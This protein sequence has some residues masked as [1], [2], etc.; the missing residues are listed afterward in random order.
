MS[1]LDLAR[2]AKASP[3]TASPA[4]RPPTALAAGAVFECVNEMER[5]ICGSHA[6]PSPARA[7]GLA[8]AGHRSANFLRPPESSAEVRTAGPVSGSPW[9]FHRFAGL[10]LPAN[11]QASFELAASTGQEAVDH[12]L[13]A[14]RLTERTG[15]TGVCT[16]DPPIAGQLDVVQLPRT[17]SLRRFL[18]ASMVSAGYTPSHP[19]ASMDELL[20]LARRTMEEVA[21]FTGRPCPPLH[22]YRMTDARYVV[23]VWG[24]AA[25]VARRAADALR[26]E[27]VRVGVVVPGLIRPFPRHEL[28]A[29]LENRKAVVVVEG[30]PRNHIEFSLLNQVRSALSL[31]QQHAQI[32]TVPD[33]DSEKNVTSLIEHLV[34]LLPEDEAPQKVFTPM[35]GTGLPS[36]RFGVVPNCPWGRRFLLDFAARVHTASPIQLGRPDCEVP[37][38]ASLVLGP[39]MGDD[40]LAGRGQI[41]VLVATHPMLL[42][43]RRMMLMM[44]DHGLLILHS[45]A[46]TEAE[47]WRSLPAD[48]RTAV[49]E[50]GV[51]LWH[52][53][54]R[55][56]PSSSLDWDQTLADLLHGAM[57]RLSAELFDEAGIA[58]PEAERAVREAGPARDLEHA[59]AC[60][61]R[62]AEEIR[63]VQPVDH[64]SRAPEAPLVHM[65]ASP[66][67]RFPDP[68]DIAD[69]DLSVQ[70]RAFH[71]TGESGILAP[72]PAPGFPL[73]PAVFTQWAVPSGR[74]WHFPYLLPDVEHDR[75]DSVLG[76]APLIQWLQVG[77]DSVDEDPTTVALVRRE[78]WRIARSVALRLEEGGDGPGLR[79][80][81]REACEQVV[82]EFRTRSSGRESLRRILNR[83]SETLPDQA[84]LVTAETAAL[85]EFY[86]HTVRR[87]RRP[88]LR[89]FL[90]ELHELL[91]QVED[92]LRIDHLHS[93]RAHSTE[94]L[95]VSLGGAA[96]HMMD[97]GV[98]AKRLPSHRGTRRL[99]PE[100][101]GR[102]TTLAED[103][104][105]FVRSAASEPDFVLVHAG[106]LPDGLDLSGEVAIWQ[107]DSFAVAIG[108]FDGFLEN[109]LSVFRAI[110]Q[111]RLEV[112]H[113]YDPAVHEAP[114][115]RLSVDTLTADELALLPRVV[116]LETE[117]V[118]QRTSLRDFSHVLQSGRPIHTLVL[119]YLT[120]ADAWHRKPGIDG[121][122]PGLSYLSVAHR[123]AFVLQAAL[124]APDQLLDGLAGMVRTPQPAVGFIGVPR[125]SEGAEFHWLQALAAAHGRALPSFT[126]DPDRGDN[127]ATRFDLRSNIQPDE[128]W[129][130]HTVAYLDSHGAH[131]RVQERLTFAHAAALDPAFRRHLRILPPAAWAD[132]QVPV[133][134]Y[135]AATVDR[136]PDTIPYLWVVDEDGV[137]QR[138]VITRELAMMCRDRMRFWTLLQELAGIN[139]EYVRRALAES[140]EGAEARL[141]AIRA[142]LEAQYHG[143]LDQVREEESV[144]TIDRL[145]N[146]LMV[147][148]PSML[149]VADQAPPPLPLAPPETKPA[150][151]AVVSP[152][153]ESDDEDDLLPAE[154]SITASLCTTCDECIKL[155]PR[156]FK[157]NQDRQAI[158]A[159]LDAC[160]FAD[161]VQAAEKCPARCIH[162]G[163]PRPGDETATE[164]MI[165]RAAEWNR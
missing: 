42:E 66:V 83:L 136:P 154:P 59:L 122:Y 147:A 162:P 24:S 133:A 51:Q 129:P 70:V 155:N 100:A 156:L 46:A 65:G 80:L 112:E 108:L 126:Y 27:G 161:L 140:A 28:A 132:D 19:R 60:L 118:L 91:S 48:V 38:V 94:E 16:L 158:I 134:D 76:P 143:R 73:C 41:D 36:L 125:P 15:M 30:S 8:L 123:E 160:T 103:L 115:R 127:W 137:L 152:A 58:L 37:G 49:R 82:Y 113:A 71:L 17:S 23:T 47:V 130:S 9:V 95:S 77:L 128:V 7:E 1:D 135:L 87:H 92:L 5:R 57:L 138:A 109:H 21:A 145:V 3:V 55:A 116:L 25:A 96:D 13:V 111:A 139:N 86:K 53:S 97:L 85:F 119:H 102:L 69:D 29:L 56:L 62:G 39:K 159:D 34:D 164:E 12:C 148:D 78:L 67:P 81:V 149:P 10:R 22:Q 74:D 32:C 88:A 120:E 26:E 105:D 157:Y 89:R 114:L 110:R 98:L 54:D 142:E 79:D 50:R 75:E 18:G 163:D 121:C 14:H 52:L 61:R 117:D 45:T 104:R 40:P 141:A 107:P 151:E 35:G 165:A 64:E 44:R 20:P 131:T 101:R 4:E 72:E 31:R 63:P 90:S 106:P 124:A 146:A 68:A 2:D 43:S 11:P 6:V 33:E 93:D 150:E 144:A 84:A 99:D 153:E